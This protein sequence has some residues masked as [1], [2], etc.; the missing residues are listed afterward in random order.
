LKKPSHNQRSTR[1]LQTLRELADACGSK[2]PTVSGWIRKPWWKWS[3]RAPWSRSIVPEINRAAADALEE[4]RGG[5]PSDPE[6]AESTKE[7]R[8]EKLRQEIRK[9]R[10]NADQAETALSKERGALLL[11]SDVEREW[12][13]VGVLVRNAVEN[14]PSQIVPLAL[15]HGMPHEAAATLQA[16]M[17]ELISGVLRHLSKNEFEE[18]E[19]RAE[20]IPSEPVPA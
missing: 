6:S 17:E 3:K 20:A 9:L 12:A 4:N 13:S 2:V 7:L 16:Q 19:D 10:A 14:L 15:T 8:D 18:S 11:A 5:R 1:H